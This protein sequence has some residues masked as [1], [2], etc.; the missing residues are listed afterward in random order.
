MTKAQASPKSG[1]PI[2]VHAGVLLAA[3]LCLWGSFNYYDFE[4]AVQ[5]QTQ[6]RDPYMIRGAMERFAG[7]RQTVSENA[8]LGYLTD[9][10]PGTLAT[11]IFGTAQYALAPRL[12]EMDTQR[13]LVL[14]NFTKPLD[15]AGFGARY[16]L[17]V[18]RDFGS[19][20]V[21]FRR[22]GR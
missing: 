19:G 14:G 12:L 7:L 15:F 8:V 2:S 4:T 20:V 18:E 17:I 5:G 10:E 1:F 16:G 3:L 11:V 9:A 22:R 6:N 13:D 21:L